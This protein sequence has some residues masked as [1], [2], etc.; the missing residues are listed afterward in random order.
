MG[1][2]LAKLLMSPQ[3]KLVSSAKFTILI[4]WSPVCTP[5]IPCH[6]HS[7]GGQSLL[8]QQTE[9]WSVGNPA[10][11]PTWRGSRGQR[12]P[13]IFIFRLH[14]VLHDSNQVDEILMQMEG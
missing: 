2:S 10:K 1:L 7:N 8:Q 4:S 11:L 12:R 3:K 14:I 9:T 6:Y 13:S 5:L